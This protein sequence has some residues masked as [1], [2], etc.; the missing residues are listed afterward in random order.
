MRT[1]PNEMKS[2]DNVNTGV[3]F[4]T[5][6]VYPEMHVAHLHARRPTTQQSNYKTSGRREKNLPTCNQRGDT[7]DRVAPFY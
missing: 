2:R 7:S 4:A 5:T 6:A 3:G 1:L